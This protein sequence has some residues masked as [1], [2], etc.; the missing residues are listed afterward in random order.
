[1]GVYEEYRNKV[2]AQAKRARTAGTIWLGIAF[3][4][5]VLQ[6]FVGE[7]WDL[8]LTTL[9]WYSMASVAL[10]QFKLEFLTGDLDATV[11]AVGIV[12]EV[13]DEAK[14]LREENKG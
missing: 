8:L 14:K 13:L 3:A 5:V 4:L 2:M 7:K 11:A 6:F 9:F 12:A 1:M 10:Y